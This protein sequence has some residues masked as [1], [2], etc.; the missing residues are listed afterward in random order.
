MPQEIR[1]NHDQTLLQNDAECWQLPETLYSFLGLEHSS[2]GDASASISASQYYSLSPTL[3]HHH[4]FFIFTTN[5]IIIIIYYF[6]VSLYAIT[7]K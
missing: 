2:R 7:C 4:F 5:I 3:G 6:S 1:D